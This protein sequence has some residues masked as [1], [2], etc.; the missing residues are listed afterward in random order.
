MVLGKLDNHWEKIRSPSYTTHKNKL[1]IDY[2]PK[3]KNETIQAIE[4]NM[5]EFLQ[6]LGAGKL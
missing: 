2:E 1:Q 4:E 5:G 3:Y 6:N